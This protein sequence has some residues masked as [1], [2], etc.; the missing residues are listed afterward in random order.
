M[1]TANSIDKS[2]SAELSEA[3]NSMFRWY[4][5]ATVCYAYLSDC[6]GSDPSRP[7]EK[8]RK[9]ALPGQKDDNPQ[10][11]H[12]KPKLSHSSRW[13]RRGWTLQE[14]IAPKVLEFLAEDWSHIGT[15]LSLQ[16]S[17]SAITGISLDVLRGGSLSAC[18]VAERMGW[19]ANRDTT[20]LED[21]AYS[22]LGIFQVHMPLLYGEGRRAFIRLQ[23]EIMKTTEDYTLFA[24]QPPDTN[25]WG[26][27]DNV[28]SP[29]ADDV[30]CF[31]EPQTELGRAEGPVFSF[32]SDPVINTT[33]DNPD[34]LEN[35][36]EEG[37][38]APQA[39]DSRPFGK[40]L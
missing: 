12:Y 4:H 37:V 20:R 2:S 13:F 34:I 30:S 39:P 7:F 1:L 35:L 22:L 36:L 32:Y 14:L 18:T 33:G 9:S 31:D 19:A 28:L 21:I 11:L 10:A 38:V 26:T 24:W 8:N 17:I 25:Y 29:L 15:K 3:I 27:A 40:Y 23:E 16:D 6:T 5:E